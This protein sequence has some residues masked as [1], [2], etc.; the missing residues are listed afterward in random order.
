MGLAFFD[1]KECE[2]QWREYIKIQ[3][4][5]NITVWELDNQ[6]IIQKIAKM[7]VCMVMIRLFAFHAI[8]N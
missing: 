2:L 3:L 4:I 6:S 5:S 8:R 1:G 7:S